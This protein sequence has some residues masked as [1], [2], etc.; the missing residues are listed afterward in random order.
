MS[1]EIIQLN[2]AIV[3]SS[4]SLNIT[5]RVVKSLYLIE[6]FI[7]KYK[8]IGAKKFDVVK[9]TDNKQ[10]FTV[11]NNLLKFTSYEIVIEP[12]SGIVH[13]SESNMIQ[14]KTK[15]DGKIQFY[16]KKKKTRKE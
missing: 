8:Q 2:E 15:E 10:R 3:L 13:G 9:I 4:T 1:G 6:G 11:L 16:S 7:I 5:W 12:Y 14:V